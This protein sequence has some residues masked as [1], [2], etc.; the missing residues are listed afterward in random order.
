MTVEMMT[1]DDDGVVDGDY[2]SMDTACGWC[3]MGDGMTATLS[4]KAA[5]GTLTEVGNTVASV[6]GCSVKV[7]MLDTDGAARLKKA[8]NYTLVVAN[9][10]TPSS[11][12][13]PVASVTVTTGLST[14]GSTA[15]SHA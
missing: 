1:P 10:P 13:N 9:V 8:T 3:G 7:G 2:V 14:T 5:D 6:S 11:G 12:D 15:R 4:E